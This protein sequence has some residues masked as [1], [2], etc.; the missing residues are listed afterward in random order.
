MNPSI[1]VSFSVE[2]VRPEEKLRCSQPLFEAG[3]GGINVSR[4]VTKLG[5]NTI[6]V[7]A[8]GGSGGELLDKLLSGE[9]IN[10]NPFKIAG[11]TRENITVSEKSSQQQY[12]FVMPGIKMSEEE[13][14]SAIDSVSADNLEADYIVAS[15]SLPPGVPDRFYAD[16]SARMKPAGLKMIVDT[17]GKPL[18]LVADQGVYMIK[19]NL[20][21]FQ[22]LCGEELQDEKQILAAGKKL[23]SKSGTE[24][25]VITL[26][27]GGCFLVNRENNTHFR[28]PTVPIRSKVG[29]GDS[30]TAGIVLKLAEGEQLCDAVR[31][32]IAA[33]AA[34][35]MTPGSELCR[36]EDTERLYKL[37]KRNGI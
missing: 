1:D 25:L 11:E 36:K 14:L 21:E 19:C 26:G 32:G 10:R 28:S 24:N 18:R 23:I 13:W 17:K 27:A 33:G 4:A 5:G 22:Q 29:A 9:N 6:A 15:G 16:L 12:R 30:M 37:L 8:S 34:A 20:R 7:F 3:G 35:V 31:Y 2:Q